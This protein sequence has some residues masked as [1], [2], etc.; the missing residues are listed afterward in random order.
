MSDGL[1]KIL[2]KCLAKMFANFMHIHLVDADLDVT[3]SRVIIEWNLC[4]SKVSY[5][6]LTYLENRGDR[7]LAQ[8]ENRFQVPT[9]PCLENCVF[10]TIFPTAFLIAT[11]PI[12]ESSSMRTVFLH[13][14]CINIYLHNFVQYGVRFTLKIRVR[15]RFEESSI[16]YLLTNKCSFTFVSVVCIVV[17][18]IQHSN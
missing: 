9:F 12:Y 14:I 6:I 3:I 1:P 7:V 18:F 15:D 11:E 13:K 10:V 8:S 2:Q 5:E 4:L 17:L 16:S